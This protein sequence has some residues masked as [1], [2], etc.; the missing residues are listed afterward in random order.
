M[1]EQ[2]WYHYYDNDGSLYRFPSPPEGCK[3]DGYVWQIRTRTWKFF[4]NDNLAV[5]AKQSG[6]FHYVPSD[7]V[8]RIIAEID[9]DYDADCEEFKRRRGERDG[10]P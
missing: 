4:P 9:A 2:Y 8:D 3:P 5:V 10:R 7:Q 1:A 6:D